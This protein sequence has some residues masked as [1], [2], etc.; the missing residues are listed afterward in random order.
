[1][2]MNDSQERLTHAVYWSSWYLVGGD[3]L[4]VK[5][6]MNGSFTAYVTNIQTVAG[7]QC[8]HYPSFFFQKKRCINKTY[9]TDRH[10]EKHTQRKR[11]K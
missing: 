7:S 5:I 8:L 11:I 6:G 10:K 9:K 1:M 3:R 2:G 4:V